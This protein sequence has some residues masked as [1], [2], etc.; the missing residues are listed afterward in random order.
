[1]PHLPAFIA[2]ARFTDPAAALAKA[3]EIYDSSIAHLR[4]AMQRFVAGEVLPGH[5]RACYPFVRVQ[6]DTV[7]RKGPSPDTAQLSFGFVAGPG[8]FETTLSRPDLYADYYLEQFTLLI[9][10][11]GVELEVGTSSQPI[12][13]HFSFAENDHIEGSLSLARR[14]LM[15]DVFDLPD[16]AAMDDGIA[17]GTYEPGPGEPQPLSLFTAPLATLHGHGTGAF[18]ELCAVY[19]LPVL[20]RRICSAGP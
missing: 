7:A 19:Q 18:S 17:N 3:R 10:N 4:E 13:V 2:P 12:P 8:R 20:H 5:V 14:Q 16:L 11:H 6:T 1:M 15:R 9:Q